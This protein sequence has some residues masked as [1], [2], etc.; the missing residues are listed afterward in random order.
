MVAPVLTVTLNPAIDLH[1]EAEAW[2]AGDVTRAESVYRSPGGKGINVSLVLHELDV[3]S[4]AFCVL[5]GPDAEVYRS[6]LRDAPFQLIDTRVDQ[7]TRTNVTIGLRASG[8]FYKVNQPGPALDPKEFERIESAYEACLRG[9]QWVVLSGGLPPG[10]PMETYARFTRRAHEAGARVLVDCEGPALLAAVEAGADWVKPNREELV[11]TLR[12]EAGESAE[13][14]DCRGI[15]EL[16]NMLLGQ[17]AG[18][19]VVSQGGGEV[20]AMDR[21]RGWR[22]VPPRIVQQSPVGAGDSMV[23][24]LLAGYLK[25]SDLAEALR[26]GV[27]CGAACAAEAEGRMAQRPL[28][29]ELYEQVR[30]E[31]IKMT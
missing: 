10:A 9:R 25:T 29:E 2:A 30:M 4:E 27:A 19:V 13:G 12:A 17:G 1:L 8:E 24:G 15:Q 23:A 26:L 18:R 21:E 5:G 31:P 7:P 16:V 6:L 28:I 14:M 20:L 22:A 3:S 11:R